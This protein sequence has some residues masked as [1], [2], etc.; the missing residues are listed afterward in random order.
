ME[1]DCKVLEKKNI[2]IGVIM[3]SVEYGVIGITEEQIFGPRMVNGAQLLGKVVAELI[4]IA[5]L[6]IIVSD[7]V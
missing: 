3:A 4:G 1:H 7:N 5:E 6:K 2:I